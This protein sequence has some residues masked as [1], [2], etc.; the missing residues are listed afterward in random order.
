MNRE[1]ILTKRA[2]LVAEREKLACQ[3]DLLDEL[4]GAEGSAP[5]PPKTAH[6]VPLPRPA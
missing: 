2:S 1:T 4:L 6:P 5:S 3:I